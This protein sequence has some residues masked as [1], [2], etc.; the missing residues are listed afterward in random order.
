V[1]T[2][3]FSGIYI[4]FVQFPSYLIPNA[5]DVLYKWFLF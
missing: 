5:T 4:I 3:D 1:S 2:L